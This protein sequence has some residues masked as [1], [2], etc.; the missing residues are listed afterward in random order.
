MPFNTKKPYALIPLFVVML[1]QLIVAFVIR[2]QF[3]DQVLLAII[4]VDSVLIILS[5][6]VFGQFLFGCLSQGN[7]AEHVFAQGLLGILLI[8]KNVLQGLLH[9]FHL[10]MNTQDQIEVD[11]GVLFVS[12][13]QIGFTNLK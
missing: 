6:E 8:L 3:L 5:A 1:F 12:R 10:W 4:L 13:F 2:K 9:F 11:Q 7:Q